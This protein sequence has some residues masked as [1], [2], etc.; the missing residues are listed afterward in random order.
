MDE[1]LMKTLQSAMGDL[2][3]EL[4]ILPL[5]ILFDWDMANPGKN[6]NQTRTQKAY[7]ISECTKKILRIESPRSGAAH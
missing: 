5:T 3:R 1:L 4:S 7:F 6:K 2:L